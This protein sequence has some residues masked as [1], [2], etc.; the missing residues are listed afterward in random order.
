MNFNDILH[1]KSSFYKAEVKILFI[2]T[3]KRYFLSFVIDFLLQKRSNQGQ[4][5]RRKMIRVLKLTK[6]LEPKNFTPDLTLSWSWQKWSL[7]SY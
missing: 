5:Y 6:G 4:V 3:K 7:V 2:F 1:L